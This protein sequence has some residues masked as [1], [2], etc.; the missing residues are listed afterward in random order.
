M[1]LFKKII[2]KLFKKMCLEQHKFAPSTLIHPAN[3]S[4]ALYE[5]EVNYYN[6]DFDCVTLVKKYPSGKTSYGIGQHDIIEFVEFKQMPAETMSTPLG[7]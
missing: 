6:Q 5:V 4:R 7:D 2:T 1:K 3:N